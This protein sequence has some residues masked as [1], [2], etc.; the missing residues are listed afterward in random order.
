MVHGKTPLN[1]HLPPFV[2]DMTYRSEVKSAGSSAIGSHSGTSLEG[3]P[4]DKTR[5]IR[6]IKDRVSVVGEQR[7]DNLFLFYKIMIDYGL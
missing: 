3:A 7:Y 6:K 2:D 4:V 5:A 1:N